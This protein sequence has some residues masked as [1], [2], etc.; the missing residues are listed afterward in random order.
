MSTYL[1]LPGTGHST[2]SVGLTAVLGIN[3]TG[4]RAS[5]S[6]LT[7]PNELIIDCI[8]YVN[9]FHMIITRE[10]EPSSA[11]GVDMKYPS[12][13]SSQSHAVTAGHTSSYIVRSNFSLGMVGSWYQ[14]YPGGH[15]VLHAWNQAFGR[16][17][18]VIHEHER[19]PRYFL[20]A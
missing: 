9:V 13:M 12:L 6:L 10:A 15:A 5:L 16:R 1:V 7:A 20:I 8:S 2:K 19:T 18:K 3:V 14:C 11:N 4:T 17:G